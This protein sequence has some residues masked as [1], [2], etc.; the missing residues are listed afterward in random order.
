MINSVKRPPK[1]SLKESPKES[2]GIEK[3]SYSKIS[4]AVFGIGL[5]ISLISLIAVVFP[6]WM[7]VSTVPNGF[8]RMGL[9]I[10]RPDMYETGSLAGLLIFSNALVFGLYI[11]RKKI[12][13]ISKIFSIDIPQ[14]VSLVIVFV[15]I[16]TYG[17]ISFSEVYTGEIYQDWNPVKV[18]VDEWNVSEI[19]NI[20]PHV[21]FFLLQQ[22]M[23]LFGSYKIIPL[24]FSMALLGITYLFTTSITKNRFSGLVAMGLVLQSYTFLTF[25]LGPCT[26]QIYKFGLIF[27]VEVSIFRGVT[28]MRG[29]RF[30]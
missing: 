7:S 9:E 22:S 24:L 16:I 4:Y 5:I 27:E 21:R 11:F 1:K 3:K 28:R 29:S 10:N 13:K 30:T 18:A 19:D 2:P 12:P 14:K 26:L 17:A 23:I 15:I 8:E 25:L 6:A 20:N